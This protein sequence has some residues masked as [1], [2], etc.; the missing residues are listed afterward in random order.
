MGSNANQKPLDEAGCQN[1]PRTV[2]YF[3]ARHTMKLCFP[4][5]FPASSVNLKDLLSYFTRQNTPGFLEYLAVLFWGFDARP[6]ILKGREDLG[7]EVV[8]LATF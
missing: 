1:T 2:E 6:A 8:F 3:V 4:R 7:A 5:L